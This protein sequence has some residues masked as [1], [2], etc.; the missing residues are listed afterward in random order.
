MAGRD[1]P[2]CTGEGFAITG[3]KLTLVINYCTMWSESSLCIP[4]GFDVNTVTRS[5]AKGESTACSMEHLIYFPF[6][7]GKREEEGE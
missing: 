7:T 1:L 2:A 6:I 4:A 5:A 3:V